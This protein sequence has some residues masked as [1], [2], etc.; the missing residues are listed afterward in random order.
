MDKMVMMGQCH[1]VSNLL[2]DCV[3]EVYLVKETELTQ[4]YLILLTSS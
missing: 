2:T 1:K 3:K 4:Y